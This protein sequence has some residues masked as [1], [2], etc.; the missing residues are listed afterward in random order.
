MQVD[1]FC[2]M[3]WIGLAHHEPQFDSSL[4][5]IGIQ[6]SVHFNGDLGVSMVA[7]MYLLSKCV[8]GVGN[9]ENMS[10]VLCDFWVLCEEIAQNACFSAAGFFT[11]GTTDFRSTIS[12]TSRNRFSKRLGRCVSRVQNV[13]WMF[14][15][16]MTLKK[17]ITIISLWVNVMFQTPQL[18]HIANLEVWTLNKKKKTATRPSI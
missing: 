4:N 7:L 10:C 15:F 11:T 2:D 8:F 17:M 6:K 12:F 16:S 3:S 5:S 13:R 14:P 1:C 18:G 9:Y